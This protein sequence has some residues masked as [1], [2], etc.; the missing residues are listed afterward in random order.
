[1]DDISL[2]LNYIIMMYEKLTATIIIRKRI[3]L[4]PPNTST[5]IVLWTIPIKR[6]TI[7]Q[8][9]C[10]LTNADAQKLYSSL[11]SYQL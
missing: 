6:F 5:S 1:M 8:I 11:Y 3:F 9:M 10:R 7:I 4:I 2:K